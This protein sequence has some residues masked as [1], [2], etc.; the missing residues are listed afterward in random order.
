MAEMQNVVPDV[1]Y[2]RQVFLVNIKYQYNLIVFSRKLTERWQ[3]G[4][5]YIIETKNNFFYQI[6]ILTLNIC[7]KYCIFAVVMV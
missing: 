6:A 4:F 7:K 5:F 3:Q 2:A 1:D